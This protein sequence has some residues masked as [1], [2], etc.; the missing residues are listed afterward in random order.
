[1]KLREQ[2]AKT[3]LKLMLD[4]RQVLQNNDTL[5]DDFKHL[6]HFDDEPDDVRIWYLETPLQELRKTNWSVRYRQFGSGLELTF[7]KR[8]SETGYKAMLENETSKMFAAEFSP[9]I[10]MQYTKKTYSLSL[11]KLFLDIEND[12][13]E[14]EA[15]RL[16]VLNSPTVFT[17]WG[18][19]NS[20][21]THLCA[22]YLYGPVLATRYKGDYEGHEAKLEI[23]KLED[24][25]A[26][27][28]FDIPTKKSTLLKRNLLKTLAENKLL[29][30]NNQLKT[31]AFLDFFCK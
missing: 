30:T 14:P 7:K 10:D 9:E 5:C 22:S 18:K 20:G 24:Y 15:K 2:I 16:A 17:D 27:I 25:L 4:C 23:W 8:Y 11:E 31:D 13:T 1:M 29:I 3:E 6:F 12:L 26:E 28:S 19:K 21:F